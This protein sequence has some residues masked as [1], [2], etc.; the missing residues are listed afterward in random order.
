ML[1]AFLGD[2]YLSASMDVNSMT[3]AELQQPL[4]VDGTCYGV[5][6]TT[7]DIA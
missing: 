5:A 6:S 7:F 2:D 1:T 3:P 4:M